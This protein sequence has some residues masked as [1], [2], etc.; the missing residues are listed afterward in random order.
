MMRILIL[1]VFTLAVIFLISET[2]FDPNLDTKSIQSTSQQPHDTQIKYRIGFIDPR[3]NLS[4]EQLLQILSEATYIWERETQ[5]SHFKYDPSAQLSINLIFDERQAESNFRKNSIQDFKNM[6]FISDIAHQQLNE[7]AE[8]LKNLKFRIDHLESQHSNDVLSYNQ[9]VNHFNQSQSNRTNLQIQQIEFAKNALE[10]K[11]LE[12]NQLILDYN[13]LLTEL[14]TETEKFN[15][16]QFSQK[17]AIDKFNQQ[18]QP[19]MFDK[20]EFNGREIN[21]YE[22]QSIDDLKITLAHEFGHA[23]GLKHSE[24]PESLMYPVLEKQNL[25][26]FRLTSADLELLNNH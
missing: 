3:F 17:D 15:Q 12:I 14:N 24:D 26:S 9:M 2:F 13:A 25:N 23:L 10:S 19:R 1:L 4:K 22:F 20:G 16:H 21:I 6:E 7:K 18:F 11:K 5:K 8:Q